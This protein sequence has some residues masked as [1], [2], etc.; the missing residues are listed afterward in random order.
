[1]TG[2][3]Y[4][5]CDY[6]GYQQLTIHFN[7]AVT[8]TAI[9]NDVRSWLDLAF[10]TK[11]NIIPHPHTHHCHHH[12][13]KQQG[14]INSNYYSNQWRKKLLG[15]PHGCDSLGTANRTGKQKQPSSQPP[16]NVGRLSAGGTSSSPF[17]VDSPEISPAQP[18]H[19]SAGWSRL[20]NIFH[21]SLDFLSEY[22]C[23]P[24]RVTCRA[25]C[26]QP[27]I[28][29]VSRNYLKLI[30]VSCYLE[31]RKKSSLPLS[32]LILVSYSINLQ[33]ISYDHTRFLNRG[34]VKTPPLFY[35]FI[36]PVIYIPY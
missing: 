34:R 26:C 28:S 2:G 27:V 1:M 35:L 9:C 11:E 24:V 31:E 22:Y 16:V 6:W 19:Q 18:S 32:Y 3:L 8:K 17:T 12:N 13:T 10:A 15:C 21:L 33:T 29:F 5:G 30:G 36:T 25:S 4:S 23:L 14:S 7:A 20:H